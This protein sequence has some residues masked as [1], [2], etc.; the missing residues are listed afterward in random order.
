MMYRLSK[1]VGL[2]GG[3]SIFHPYRCDSAEWYWSPHFHTIGY[4]WIQGTKEVYEDQGWIVKNIGVRKDVVKVVAYALSHA[5]IRE[6]QHTVTWFGEL[7]Y[8]K[9]KVELEPDD[10]NRCPFCLSPLILLQ[11]IATDRG[12]PIPE[13]YEGLM[14]PEG[15][16]IKISEWQLGHSGLDMDSARELMLRGYEGLESR[17]ENR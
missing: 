6:G 5:G 15:W 9:L 8:A 11:W 2:Y 12:P 1:I 14:D 3:L 17:L 4:E 7:G 16:E 10:E 13:D